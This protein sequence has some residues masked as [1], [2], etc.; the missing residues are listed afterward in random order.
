MSEVKGSEHEVVEDLDESNLLYETETHPK[1]DESDAKENANVDEE[2]EEEESDEGEEE[3]YDDDDDDVA[4][5]LNASGN[6]DTI[7]GGVGVKFGA[8]NRWQRP[9][10]V[11]GSGNVMGSGVGSG[12]GSGGL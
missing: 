5:V 8:T 10:V 3:D 2:S 4:V 12:T 11:S 1:V 9:G 6:I 7:G